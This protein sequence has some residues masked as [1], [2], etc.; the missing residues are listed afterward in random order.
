M[1]DVE[2]RQVEL[3][4]SVRRAWEYPIFSGSL[5]KVFR[6][7]L[8]QS[9]DAEGWWL[10]DSPCVEL[11]RWSRGNRRYLANVSKGL[12]HRGMMWPRCKT[13]PPWVFRCCYWKTRRIVTLCFCSHSQSQMTSH[14]QRRT[15]SLPEIGSLKTWR[16]PAALGCGV[17][18]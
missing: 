13:V 14:C 6:R 8:C 4:V 9:F 7:K 10:F 16:I 15:K 2:P 3:F 1:F 18:C 11:S 17:R 12:L 5:P